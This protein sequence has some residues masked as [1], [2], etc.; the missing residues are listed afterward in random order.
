MNHITIIY[1]LTI[2]ANVNFDI[3]NRPEIHRNYG[4]AIFGYE[5]YCIQI[6]VK[7]NLEKQTSSVSFY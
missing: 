2:N 1:W 5:D 4:Q 6:E 7:T 3:Y